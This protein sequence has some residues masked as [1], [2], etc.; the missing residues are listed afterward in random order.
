MSRSVSTVSDELKRNSVEAEYNSRKAHHKAYARRKYSKFQGMKIVDHPDLRAFVEDKLWTGRSPESISGRLSHH[1][2]TLPSVSADSIERFLASPY[3]RQLEA[4]RTQ[5]K[6]AQRAKRRRKRVSVTSLSDRTFID[7][8]PEIINR[9]GRVGDVEADFIVSG[10]AG[11]GILLTVT[12]RKLRVSFIEKILP[13]TIK[14]VHA[15]FKRV[16]ARYPELRTIST[17]NDIL[18]NQH[19]KLAQLLKVKI[20]FCHPYHSWEKGTIENTNGVIR[21][22]IPKGSD[23]SQYSRPFIAKLEVKLND[24]YMKC[25]DYA[26]PAEVLQTYRKKQE[27]KKQ[28]A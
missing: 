19:T 24:R 22:T 23:L 2:P 26:T 14:N 8:R 6:R 28:R 4:H 17:D 25:L 13:V 15:A 27:N 9:R 11:N 1:E 12:D 21:K 10:K 16:Q 5:L 18:L 3:G 20:Y 7:Q